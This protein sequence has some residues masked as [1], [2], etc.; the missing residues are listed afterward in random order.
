MKTI[1]YYRVTFWLGELENGH[2]IVNLPYMDFETEDSAKEFAAKQKQIGR[3][4]L[5]TDK[6][7]IL[8]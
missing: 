3:N 2:N 6:S 4:T 8:H 7:L 5:I 1:I